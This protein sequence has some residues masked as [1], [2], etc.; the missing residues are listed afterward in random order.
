LPQ[1][2]GFLTSVLAL[3]PLWTHS[4]QKWNLSFI[5]LHHRTV[6]FWTAFKGLKMYKQYQSIT[7]YGARSPASNFPVI[8]NFFSSRIPISLIRTRGL[9]L[10]LLFK[11]AGCIL[12]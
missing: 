6:G 8:A 10:F 11:I 1:P 9:Y 12:G 2:L 5:F 3:A 4:V 7:H